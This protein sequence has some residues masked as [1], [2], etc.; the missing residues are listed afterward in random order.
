M[1][2]SG[3]FQKIIS[4]KRFIPF[5]FLLTGFS[6]AAQ[7]PIDVLHYEFNIWLGDKN[8]T[9]QGDT[10]I[11]IRI[12]E[13]TDGFNL[14][15]N[16]VNS[17]GKGM[18][19]R[20]LQGDGVKT[21]TH[22]DN[23]IWIQ[24][25]RRMPEGDTVYLTIRYGGIPSDGLIISKS[26]YGR[27]TFF[28]DNWPNRAH[29]WIPCKDEPGDK[30]QVDFHVTAPS[31]YSVISNGVLAEEIPMSGQLKH[32][33][34]KETVPI[35]T[36]V[37]V[38]GVA[39]FAIQYTGTVLGYVPVSSWVFPESSTDGFF[40]YEPARD[41]LTWLDEYIGPYPYKKLANIQSKT[42]FGGMENASAIF[43]FEGS[44]T[45][46]R[47]IESLLCH[48]I[49]HQFF[50]NHATEKTFAH[51]WLSEGFATYLT[52]VFLESKY[53]TDSL[54]SRMRNERKEVLDFVARSKRPVVDN[55]P[56]FMSL[57]NA[58]SYQK[59]GWVLHMLRRELGDSIFHKSI[60]DYYS[61]YAGRNADS[62]DLQAI[63]EAN[64]DKYLTK[65]F[66]QWLYTPVNPRLDISWK[67]TDAGKLEITVN[68][69]QEGEP[70]SFPLELALQF[71]NG[72]IQTPKLEIT[73]KNETFTLPNGT[74]L[75]TVLPDP[76]SSLLADF[77]V[78]GK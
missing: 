8:D 75:S 74:G 52:H 1:I 71:S 67:T 19:V 68:Q 70:F 46:K 51:L 18:K 7:S 21:Y 44:V 17:S 24:L 20:S 40:D 36:K 69:L 76:N 78:S 6:A 31:H 28:S 62:R 37:M 58:N 2:E 30:A 45:G 73:R 33:H 72:E 22:K 61:A 35:A 15:L 38:I 29:H 56:D 12:A 59:G 54:N 64:S 3:I 25:E 34:W 9:I 10:R 32:T 11:T 43:Y 60:R 39:E 13:P 41:I 47:Q 55:T 66:T 23:K 49:V 53:G 65:F 63:F 77:R 57:L 4:V 27:R 26:K 5:V 14:D 42:T 16:S 50:G 48:E